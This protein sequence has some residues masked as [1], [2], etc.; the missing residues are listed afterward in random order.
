MRHAH[1]LVL[2]LAAL[3]ALV[4]TAA[5]G[6]ALTPAA[7]AAGAQNRVGAF[8]PAAPTLAG[9][10]TAQ[11][12]CSRPGSVAS[13]AQIASGF[14]VAA[15][16]LPP[17]ASPALDGSPYSPREVSLRQSEWRRQ[18]GTGNLDPDSPIPDQGPGENLGGQA[19]EGYS[20]STGE[21]NVSPGEEHSRTPKGAPYYGP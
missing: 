17:G 14:C 2:L 9:L 1:R 6:V 16:E 5:A 15:E 7:H 13:T 21:R 8:T 10:A 19:N 18:L 12:P 20:H 4:L 11:S 3:T